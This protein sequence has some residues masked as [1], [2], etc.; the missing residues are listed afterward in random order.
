MAHL[1]E[2]SLTAPVSAVG[3]GKISSTNCTI[4]KTRNKEKEARNGPSFIVCTIANVASREQNI[5][6]VQLTVKLNFSDKKD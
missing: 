1:V 3:L 4:E 2:Q 6:T 5:L